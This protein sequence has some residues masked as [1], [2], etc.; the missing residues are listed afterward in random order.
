MTV[1]MVNR[2]CVYIFFFLFFVLQPS[3]SF[4][5]I[6][7]YTDKDGTNHYTNVSKLSD[8]SKSIFIWYRVKKGDNLYGLAKKYNTSIIAIL[9]ANPD[10]KKSRKIYPDQQLNIPYITNAVDIDKEEQGLS[11]AESDFELKYDSNEKVTQVY[12]KKSMIL[13]FVLTWGIGLTPPLLIRFFI[14]KRPMKYALSGFGVIACFWFLNILIFTF[15]GSTSKTHGPSLLVGFASYAILRKGSLKGTDREEKC[16]AEEKNS[17]KEHEEQKY[18]QKT[19]HVKDGKYY[20]D[21]FG[22]SENCNTEDIKRRY[23][24]LVMQYHPDKVSHLGLRLKETAE[25]EIKK[26]NEAY[27]Y[28]K[29]KDDLR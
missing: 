8:P 6:Y 28:F 12:N 17:K 22:L 20:R 14:L 19:K 15:M 2:K 29:N 7:K 5:D 4:S 23:R 1:M 3:L 13:F 27:S 10:I 24:E 26:I 11:K 25:N 21:F 18:H 9:D 16:K